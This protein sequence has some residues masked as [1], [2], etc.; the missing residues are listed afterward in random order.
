MS[1][2]FSDKSRTTAYATFFRATFSTLKVARSTHYNVFWKIVGFV[3]LATKIL[4]NT[5]KIYVKELF[6]SRVG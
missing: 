3:N 5:S 2:I 6:F 4:K 1:A